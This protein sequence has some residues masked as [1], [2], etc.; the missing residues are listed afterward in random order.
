MAQTA[1][2]IP[3]RILK[4]YI[5]TV[6]LEDQIDTSFTL[7]MDTSETTT[8]DNSNRA[9]TF[10]SDY[11][12]GTATVSGYLAFDATEGVTQAIAA[13]K[14]GTAT[15]LLW[16]TGTTGNA[17]YSSSSIPT[18]VNVN[19]PKDG[20]GSFSFDFQFTGDFTESTTGA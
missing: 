17:T 20:P 1:G 12:T 14:A 2:I 4:M 10:Q 15:T 9:K 6:V 11:W 8:K 19:M 18:N 7:T 3:G 13:L 16:D 5:D